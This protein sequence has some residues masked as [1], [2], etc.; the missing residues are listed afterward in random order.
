MS[1]HHCFKAQEDWVP[2]KV[3]FSCISWVSF[4]GGDGQILTEDGELD[5]KEIKETLLKRFGIRAFYFV[6]APGD[7]PGEFE[8]FFEYTITHPANET[9]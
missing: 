9:R 5:N 2:L 1:K 7:Y 3:S 6:W 8:V 4:S